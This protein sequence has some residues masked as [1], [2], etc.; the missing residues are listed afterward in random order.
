[1]QSQTI[2]DRLI[3]EITNGQPIYYK[4]YKKETVIW[5]TTQSQKI[6]IAT[7]NNEWITYNWSHEITL[8]P[9]CTFS[10][11]ELLDNEGI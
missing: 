5:I 2:N 3:Y 6:M 7:N 9:N 1:M 8:L 11:Q 10:V 4:N